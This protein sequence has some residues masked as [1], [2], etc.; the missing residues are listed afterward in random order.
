V[1]ASYFG[2]L[3]TQ[4]FRIVLIYVVL[5]ALSV[6]ALLGFTYWNTR[7]TL[8]AQTDQIIEAEI[9]GLSEQYQQLG[10]RG[11]AE[12]VMSRSQ[13]GGQGLYLLTDPDR[14]R[15]AGNLDSWPAIKEDGSNFVEFD[16]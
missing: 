10:M 9:T 12:A 14:R 2:V 6:S 8:D 1:R 4:A 15:I 16:Y 3:R 13:H 7:R 5:F 11:L